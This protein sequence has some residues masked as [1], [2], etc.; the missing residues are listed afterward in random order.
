[1]QLATVTVSGICLV[2]DVTLTGKIDMCTDGHTIAAIEV[3]IMAMVARLR[4]TGIEE[5]PRPSIFSV[6]ASRT[7]W[8][9]PEDLVENGVP[10]KHEELVAIAADVRERERQRAEHVRVHG[11]LGAD[12]P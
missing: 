12:W 4:G 8:V 1:M 7:L 10:Y 11:L 6:L 3:H 2:F 9:K 5:L